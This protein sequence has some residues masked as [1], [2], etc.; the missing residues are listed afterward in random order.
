MTNNNNMSRRDF[1][2]IASIGGAGVVVGSTGLGTSLLAINHFGKDNKHTKHKVN[3]YG[4]YQSGIISDVQK[5]VYFVV[6]ELHSTEVNE[7][8]EM[9]KQW[10]AHSIKLMNGDLIAPLTNNTMLP[11][12]DTGEAKGL[13]AAR[14]TL[15]YGVSPTFF[16]KLKITEKRPKDLKDLPHFPKDQL[17]DKFTGGDIFIQACSDDPQVNFHAIRNLIRASS[18]IVTMKW[19]QTGFNSFEEKDGKVQTPRNLF[20]FKDG[21]GN[22]KAHEQ[23]ALDQYIF[24]NSGWEKN[25]SYLVVR[26]IQMHLETWDR[27]ALEDQEAT[28]GRHRDSGAPL[29]KKNEFDTV[30]IEEKD[31]EGNYVIP[32]DSHVHLAKKAKTKMLRRSF[33][34]TN[35]V[36]EQTGA[37]DAGLIFVSYQKSPEQF[38]RI[39]NMLG[40][41]DR[42]N[43]YITHRGSGVFLVF[44]GIKEGGYIGE[45]LFNSI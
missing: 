26:K 31:K 5:H 43:E 24:A 9:F 44:P 32:E 18:G 2:K 21:T 6:L 35:G 10:T 38:T 25:G 3:F 27:T 11:T 33:S 40:R 13:D 22:P 39:Q 36:N 7:V 17:D 34:Y 20:S 1:L 23:D 16:D 30:N 29:G 15:T 12:I 19:A 14:L 41:I 28:F 8:K 45:T 42:M 37:F 4:K